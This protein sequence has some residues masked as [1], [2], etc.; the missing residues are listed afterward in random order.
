MAG[1]CAY[2][3]RY[4]NQYGVPVGLYPYTYQS[5]IRV[6]AYAVLDGILGQ[7]LQ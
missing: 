4:F 3:I 5:S 2:R 7:W 6:L 1:F